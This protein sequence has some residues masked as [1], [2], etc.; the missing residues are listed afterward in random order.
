MRP[1]RKLTLKQV[2]RV[3]TLLTFVHAACPLSSELML[4]NLL[5]LDS[6]D[7]KLEDAAFFHRCLAAVSQHCA[8]QLFGQRLCLGF[9][10]LDILRYFVV[11]FFAVFAP[12]DFDV[13]IVGEGSSFLLLGGFEF[14][15]LIEFVLLFL[16]SGCLF[17]R[18]VCF[19]LLRL[20]VHLLLEILLF[21]VGLLG[22]GIY[23]LLFA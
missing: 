22:Y 21:S 12:S 17:L 13:V 14:E 11:L 18:W 16:T 15:Q 10:S 6:N 5:D 9:G 8:K 4:E 1:L 3:S 23:F 2:H 20:R 19:L 7:G